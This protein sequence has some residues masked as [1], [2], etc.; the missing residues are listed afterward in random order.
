[1]KI[2]LPNK[3]KMS[4]SEYLNTVYDMYKDKIKKGYMEIANK[5]EAFIQQIYD[6][7]KEKADRNEK[8][9]VK[10]EVLKELHRDVYIPKS[11]K[12]KENV[13]SG[14]KK[15][16]LYKKFQSMLRDKKGR[17]VKFDAKNLVYQGKGEYL[18]Q[19]DYGNLY[20]IKTIPSPVEIRLYDMREQQ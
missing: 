12:F 2:K 13:I 5:R 14:L 10:T 6:R 16:N 20:I 19:D 3:G 15:Y 18:Y 1:M 11:E 17:F 9:N 8:T 4:N 7:M